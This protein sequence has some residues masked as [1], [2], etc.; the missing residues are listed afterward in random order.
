[1]SIRNVCDIDSSPSCAIEILVGDS[2]CQDI[3]REGAEE[4]VVDYSCTLPPGSGRKA[5]SIVHSDEVLFGSLANGPYVEYAPPTI[6]GVGGCMRRLTDGSFVNEAEL[7]PRGDSRFDST[8]DCDWSGSDSYWGLSGPLVPQSPQ[9]VLQGFSINR[10]HTA[11]E[12]EQFKK[13]ALHKACSALTPR[14]RLNRKLPGLDLL[15][16]V[17]ITEE[18]P[19]LSSVDTPIPALQWMSVGGQYARITIHGQN[20]G[21]EDAPVAV[22][23]DSIECLDPTHDPSAPQVRLTCV[24]APATLSNARIRVVASYAANAEQIRPSEPGTISYSDCPPGHFANPAVPIGSDINQTCRACS[25][26]RYRTSADS[27]GMHAF[28]TSCWACP[29]GTFTS[30]LQGASSCDLCPVGRF[31]A[32]ILPPSAYGYIATDEA[33]SQLQVGPETNDSDAVEI[34]CIVCPVGKYASAEGAPLCSD[35]PAGYG[36]SADRSE[37]LPCPAGTISNRDLSDS[38]AGPCV[39]CPSGTSRD[40]GSLTDTCEICPPGYISPSGTGCEA[41]PPGRYSASNQCLSC[42]A[43][44]YAAGRGN[45]YCTLCPSGHYSNANDPTECLPCSPGTALNLTTFGYIPRLDSTGAQAPIQCQMCAPGTFGPVSGMVSCLQ[46]PPGSMAAAPDHT[47]VNELLPGMSTCAACPPGTYRP[48]LTSEDSSDVSALK[49]RYCP[50]GRV[51]SDAISTQ[52]TGATTCDRYP[53]GTEA[54][55][56]MMNGAALTSCIPCAPGRFS[57]NEYDDGPMGRTCMECSAGKYAPSYGMSAC[58]SCP[59]GLITTAAGASSCSPCEVGK[60]FNSTTKLCTKSDPGR[61]VSIEGAVEAVECPA[62]RFTAEYG[63]TTCESCPAGRHKPHGAIA[64][65]AML[66]DLDSRAKAGGCEACAAGK[67]AP[68]GSAA[69]SDCPA[70]RY[71]DVEKQSQCKPCERGKYMPFAGA[72]RLDQPQ[73]LQCPAG[74]YAAEEGQTTCAQCPAGKFSA[75]GMSGCSLCSP[76]KFASSSGSSVCRDCDQG[77]FADAHGSIMCMTCAGSTGNR[78]T[79]AFS[80]EPCGAGRYL[81]GQKCEVCSPGRYSNRE[82]LTACTEC[83]PGRFNSLEQQTSCQ[84]CSAGSMAQYPGQILCD[85][86]EAGRYSSRP[87]ANNCI[88]CPLGTYQH[89]MG[90]SYCQACEP[91]TFRGPEDSPTACKVCEPGRFA[92][93]SGASGC[94]DCSPGTYAPDAKM[95]ACKTCEAGRSQGKSGESFCYICDAG[96]FGLP[97]QQDALIAYLG[98]MHRCQSVKTAQHVIEAR[99]H[100]ISTA[101]SVYRVKPVAISPRKEALCATY[102]TLARLVQQ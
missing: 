85:L 92:A 33:L 8:F 26:G 96:R 65:T 7:Q 24:L 83:N 49:C 69:C 84:S 75:K 31:R 4:N 56:L 29:A 89:R 94:F 36:S 63:A 34:Q 19:Q 76:G 1:M 53:V 16:R 38:Q 18:K 48:P 52:Y 81:D 21:P 32:S 79:G 11:G 70:G 40:A 13:R 12:L 41:C 35:C 59:P 67:Y 3:H 78:V 86:C 23:V 14:E 87:G 6:T 10:F 82:G 55:T 30:K 66:P 98:G 5:I 43:G 72:G 25:I 27:G 50:V 74:S 68:E 39:P 9:G 95:T 61:Y 58:M 99:S 97:V 54:S 28:A 42:P 100:L 45:A 62:G 44:R 73:C 46:C 15:A 22:S 101:R 90:A 2:I 60:F 17:F 57:S 88:A 80:C 102:A 91:G 71:A 64:M 77:K 47:S 51:T 37:C 20:F 93:L